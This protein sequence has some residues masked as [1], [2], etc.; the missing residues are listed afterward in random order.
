[1]L[2]EICNTNHTFVAKYYYDG[3]VKIMDYNKKIELHCEKVSAIKYLND[4]ILYA[5]R[6]GYTELD[7]IIKEERTF[8]NI[9]VPIAG[10]LKYYENTKDVKFNI[11]MPAGGYIKHTHID[12]PL[13]VQENMNNC[14]IQNPFDK[15]WFFS[16]DREIYELINYYL[17]SIRQADIIAEG[18]ITSIEWC[19]NEVLDNILQHSDIGE[20]Y[21]MG[22][23]HPNSK[24]LSF[25]IFDAGIGIYN[26]LRKSNVHNPLS[27]LDAITMALQEKVTRDNN[28]GQ[29]NGLWGLS[30]IILQA[31]GLLRVSS[32]G[33]TYINNSGENNTINYGHFNLGKALGTTTI[34]FQLDYSKKMDISEAL[35]GYSYQPVDLWLE[36]IESDEDENI[37]LI[38]VY[39]KSNGTGTRK[40]AEKLRNMII[41]II[42]NN[43]KKI[44]LDF[45]GVNF[46]SSSFADELIGKIIKE[47]GFVFFTQT[48]KMINLKPVIVNIINRSVEQR[49]AQTY[50]DNNIKIE[51]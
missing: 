9:C 39:E 45:N 1:M 18:V 12:N 44:V 26:S 11:T 14:I 46:I 31:N 50:Y 40:S 5:I 33:A 4:N 29:G 19:L 36:N 23:I 47:Q 8:S 48:L 21:I 49:M 3:S 16:T 30:N 37:V 6:Q 41:N 13:I 51:E 7:I 24:R 2:C 28:I 10:I 27:P 32:G 25:C 42:I 17:L 34:D 35:T 22:Q 15:V 20:G 43:Q 38:D